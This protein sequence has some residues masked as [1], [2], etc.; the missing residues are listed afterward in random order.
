MSNNL[1]VVIP[2]YNENEYIEILLN[3]LNESFKE[4]NNIE[5]ILV[6]DCSPLPLSNNL[7]TKKYT[8]DLKI[9]RN[10]VNRGQTYSIQKGIADSKYEN[11]GLIDGD[12]QNPPNELRRSF[13]IFLNKDLDAIVSYRIKRKDKLSKII[14]SKL[15][16]FILRLF[17]KTKFRDFG[18]S[19]KIIKKEHLE[20]IKLDGD[21][22]RLLSPILFSRNLKMEEIGVDHKPR[23]SGKTNYGIGRIVPVIVDG[24]TF[25]LSKGYT[26]PKR[27]ALGKIS[28]VLM[29]LFSISIAIVSY[30]KLMFDIFVHRNPVFLLGIVCFISAVQIFT[31]SLD[32][33][34]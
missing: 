1:T 5:V 17:T 31:S 15:G 26:M 13:D 25:M 27:Y 24:I 11:I 6:D 3:D 28:F 19:L 22:H 34:D 10:E 23:V 20:K 21:L 2:C 33:K 8:F 14:F 7:D 32:L 16:N 30:Q 9:I 4:L 18:S 29:I 12:G